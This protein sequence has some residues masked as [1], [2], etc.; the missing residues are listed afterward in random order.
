MTLLNIISSV[1]PQFLITWF[2]SKMLRSFNIIQ[3]IKGSRKDSQVS[4]QFVYPDYYIIE[5]LT[6]EDIDNINFSRNCIL[7]SAEK[8]TSHSK[9]PSLKMKSYLWFQTIYYQHLRSTFPFCGDEF[10]EFLNA[11]FNFFFV[12]ANDDFHQHISRIAEESDILLSEYFTLGDILFNSFTEG[13]SKEI[14]DDKVLRSWR[15][16][17]SHI[18]SSILPIME[19]KKSHSHISHESASL[20]MFNSRVNSMKSIHVKSRPSITTESSIK[21]IE[22]SCRLSPKQL[23]I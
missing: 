21:T 3:K 17:Y 1:C 16:V 5:E 7:N 20:D 4:P 2:Q 10:D 12:E 6:A 18:I 8:R 9:V 11:L 19:T 22:A 14:F 13:L 23:K 15:K